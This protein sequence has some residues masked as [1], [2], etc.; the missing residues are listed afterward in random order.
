[1]QLERLL[2]S[3]GFGSRKQ[4]GRRIAAGDVRIDGVVCDDPCAEIDSGNSQIEIDGVI[5]RYREKV[6]VAMHKPAG[7]E[8]THHARCY[9][10]VYT[11]LP[12]PLVSR[13]VQTVG[14]LDADTTGLLLF[15]DDG[16]FIHALTSPR[17]HI[18]KGYR[19]I[20]KHDADDRFV[21]RMANGVLLRD[22]TSAIK[23]LSVTLT[24][25]KTLLLEID[26]GKFHQVK[27]MVA[28]A[29]NRV[30][31]LHRL[32]MGGLSLAGDLLLEEGEW[33][34]LESAHLDRLGYNV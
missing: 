6:Y 34:Y 5:W 16:H 25:A 10:S 2:Q 13:G 14:R 30:A 3:Q 21:R 29:G 7:Y 31:V 32:A 17:R 9:P 22:E 4:C 11:L 18:T 27:R 28:A 24:D 15:S 26:Q 8:C 19:V 20:L 33:R 12:E 1:M 23:P